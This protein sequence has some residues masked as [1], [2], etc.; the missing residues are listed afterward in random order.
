MISPVGEICYQNENHRIA[1]GQTG[2]LSKKLYDE[3]TA[4]QYG[5]KKDPYGWCVRIDR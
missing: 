3:I 1:D 2:P 4:I 5:L